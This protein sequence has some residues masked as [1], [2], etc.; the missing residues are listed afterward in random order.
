VAVIRPKTCCRHIKHKVNISATP[1]LVAATQTLPP[2]IMNIKIFIILCGLS[3]GQ[4]PSLNGNWHL[5]KV[6]TKFWTLTPKHDYYLSF[7][8]NEIEFNLDINKCSVTNFS[9]DDATI[10]YDRKECTQVCCD[11]NIDS[12][13]NYI[14]YNGVFEL[15][16]SL[17]IF[18]NDKAKLYLKRI[19]NNWW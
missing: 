2:I 17:L 11:G 3:L 9:I 19:K 10:K 6:E 7:T 15:Q 5:Y 8:T 4:Y 18:S 13:A 16:D 1:I 14:D 12:I